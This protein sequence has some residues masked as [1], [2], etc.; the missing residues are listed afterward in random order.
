MMIIGSPVGEG[1][2]DG[3]AVCVSRCGN[4][5]YVGY[6]SGRIER[7]NLQSGLHRGTFGQGR[8]TGAGGK[9]SGVKG[10]KEE[11]GHRGAVRGLVID[12]TQR[13]LVSAGHGTH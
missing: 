8:G 4:F 11:E 12:G 2:G 9:G 1:A 5:S 6:S 10:G 7:Y 13:M 3:T